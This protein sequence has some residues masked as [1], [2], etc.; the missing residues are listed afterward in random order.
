M[1][2]FI[3]RG[4]NEIF[5]N[6][7]EIVNEN[8]YAAYFG[9]SA[10][11]YEIEF[12]ENNPPEHLF[13]S[14]IVVGW[15]SSVKQ[16]LI[17]LGIEPP[18]EIDYPECLTPFYKRKLWK[19]T[20]HK[21]YTD[22]LS[23]PV[24]VKPVLGKQ[25]NGTLVKSLT[26]LV[27]LGNQVDREIW[28]SEPIDFLSEYRC[29]VRYGKILGCKHY[30]GAWDISPDKKTVESAIKI[31]EEEKNVPASYCM[32]FGVTKDFTSVVEVNDGYSAGTYGL[33]AILYAKFISARWHQ[34]VNIPDPLSY[35]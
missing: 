31:F 29:F 11:G 13:R 16:A 27:G 24:F 28:C 7:G 18:T 15:I 2:V 17:N 1:R 33:Q 20:L 4:R 8:C 32:D 14:D 3:P 25:F 12:Y 34:M 6:E 26:D 19:S 5:L 35:F 10:L 22:E 9:F 30:K 21:V 23:W